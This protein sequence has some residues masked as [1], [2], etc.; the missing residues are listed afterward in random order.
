M[1]SQVFMPGFF[2]AGI[3]DTRYGKL[4]GNQHENGEN[5]YLLSDFLIV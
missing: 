2:H 5:Q 4:A 3:P 1:K